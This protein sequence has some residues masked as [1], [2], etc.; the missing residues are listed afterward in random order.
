MSEEKKEYY[1]E[2]S[3]QNRS[4]YETKRKEFEDIKKQDQQTQQLK[5]IAEMQERR[6]Q[7]L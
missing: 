4:E 6:K 2:Q 3:L 5:M 1:K 7:R